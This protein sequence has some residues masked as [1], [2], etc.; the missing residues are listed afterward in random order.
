MIRSTA[1]VAS[2][3][4]E[5]SLGPSWK[6]EIKTAMDVPFACYIGELVYAQSLDK[7]YQKIAVCKFIG[8]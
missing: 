3:L 8:L 1:Q 4:R 7:L 2:N 6:S 5:Y